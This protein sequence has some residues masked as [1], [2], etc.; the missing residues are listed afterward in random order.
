MFL[1]YFKNQFLIFRQKKRASNL[2][3]KSSLLETMFKL[4][5]EEFLIC[6]VILSYWHQ[7]LASRPSYRYFLYTRARRLRTRCQ[8]ACRLSAYTP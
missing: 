7:L 6:G 2:T 1:K 5:K 8:A 4:K 3:A